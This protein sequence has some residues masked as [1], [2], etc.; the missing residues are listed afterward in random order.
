LTISINFE[1]IKSHQTSTGNA[2]S[3]EAIQLN[4]EVDALAS[5][6]YRLNTPPTHRGVFYSGVVC[7]HQDGYHIQDIFKAISSHESDK[8]L[9]DY[10]VSKGWM[11]EALEKVDWPGMHK[12]LNLLSPI[13]CCNAIQMLH[14]WQNT[15]YQKGQFFYSSCDG[16]NLTAEQN[17]RQHI[18]KCPLGCNQVETLFHFIT[19]PSSKMCKARR[20]GLTTIKRTFRKLHTAPSLTEAIIDGIFCHVDQMEYELFPDSDPLLFDLNHSVL[21]SNQ[22]EIRWELFIKGFI[23]KDWRYIQTSYYSYLKLDHRKYNAEKWV[24]CLLKS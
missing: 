14:N 22:K 2:I 15:G 18:T 23:S 11:M 6:V 3:D 9:L 12:F 5:A 10:Y 8:N 1:W 13:A 16:A 24:G 19:C 21:L 20:K 4:N 7:F 17:T